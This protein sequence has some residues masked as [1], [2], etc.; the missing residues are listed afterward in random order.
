MNSSNQQQAID[1]IIGEAALALMQQGGPVNLRALI[2]QLN[3][4]QLVADEAERGALITLALAKI[5][6]SQAEGANVPRKGVENAGNVH[7][8]FAGL[9]ISPNTRKH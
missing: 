6:E 3:E 7:S 5:R 2:V 4:M 1:E 9:K 8:Q